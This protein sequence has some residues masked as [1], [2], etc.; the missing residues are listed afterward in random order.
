MAVTPNPG[1]YAALD[2]AVA[3]LKASDDTTALSAIDAVK[4]ALYALRSPV[5][6]RLWQAHLAANEQKAKDDNAILA[7]MK[8]A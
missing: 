1:P 3:A 4:D 7:A 6:D 8:V 2:A 5:Q